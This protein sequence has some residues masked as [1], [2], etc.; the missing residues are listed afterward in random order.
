V[1]VL[2]PGIRIGIYE[3][4]ATIGA[5]GMG[6]VFHARDTRLKR[7]LTTEYNG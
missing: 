3:I 2:A 5:G 7:D 4:L 1:S 6:E